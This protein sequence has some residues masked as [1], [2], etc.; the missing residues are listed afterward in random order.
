[1]AKS[2]SGSAFKSPPAG[3]TAAGDS[4][5]CRT[6]MPSPRLHPNRRIPPA[7]PARKRRRSRRSH[8]SRS[9]AAIVGQNQIQKAAPGERAW[10]SAR[11][12]KPSHANAVDS[13]RKIGRVRRFA[14]T[15]GRRASFGSIRRHSN[16]FHKA[17]R[18]VAR[19]TLAAAAWA[20]GSISAPTQNL[21]AVLA[22]MGRQ[23]ISARLGKNNIFL[24][25]EP[26]YSIIPNQLNAAPVRGKG[27]C[28]KELSL[29]AICRASGHPE[30]TKRLRSLKSAMDAPCKKLAWTWVRRRI[31][32]GSAPSRLGIG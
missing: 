23:L 31:C 8:L 3:G 15:N 27:S 25:I 21:A 17:L 29:I 12:C 7:T 9:M 14:R 2:C 26:A 18:L 11:A 32:L 19:A 13:D 1:M 4:V 30:A 16:D 10:A 24:A 5:V 6:S 20:R 22:R 28:T